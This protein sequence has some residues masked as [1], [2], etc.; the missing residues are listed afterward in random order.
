MNQNSQWFPCLLQPNPCLKRY[1]VPTKAL[2]P[3]IMKHDHIMWLLPYLSLH[4]SRI[5]RDRGI[6]WVNVSFAIFLSTVE[7]DFTRVHINYIQKDN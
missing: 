7:C 2:L 4:C 5:E 6:L 1:S 3:C